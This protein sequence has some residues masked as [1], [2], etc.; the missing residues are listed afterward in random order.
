LPSLENLTSNS[1]QKFAKIIKN[2]KKFFQI[3]NN[4]EKLRTIYHIWAKKVRFG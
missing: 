3:W 2:S 4:F 1:K